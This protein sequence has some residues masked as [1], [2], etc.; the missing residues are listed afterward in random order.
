MSALDPTFIAALAISALLV[1][2]LFA[3]RRG[4]GAA[5]K[6]S[7]TAESLDT[8]QAWTPQAVRVMTSAE[9]EAYELLRKAV[10]GQLVLAQVPLARFISVPTRHSYSDW[11]TRVGRLSVDLLVCD[12]S[13]RVVLAIDVRTP[14]ESDR[15]QQRHA[16]MA[17]VL[18]AAGIR[19]VHWRADA[20]P[21]VND[22]RAQ[23]AELSPR[24][25]GPDSVAPE[26]LAIGPN[27]RRVLPLPEMV[28]V[29]AEGDQALGAGPQLEPVSSDYFDDL[30]ALAPRPPARR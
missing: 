28:E 2:L 8:I 7:S 15:A 23:V 21:S 25:A 26:P 13:S 19:V 22:V 4:T 11:L 1:S 9:R 27:G 30:D 12:H 6:R 14:N 17:E 18:R 16:R 29:L 5:K 3:R 24:A 20:L 10:P